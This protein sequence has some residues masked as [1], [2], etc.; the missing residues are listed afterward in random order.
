MTNQL[1]LDRIRAETPGCSHVLHFN[2][3]G[4]SL[5]PQPV[6]DAQL[7]HLKLEAQI[8]GYEAAA[9]A[10]EQIEHTYTAIAQLINAQPAEIAVVENATV[11]WQMAFAS[12]PFKKGD[13]I[14]TAQASYASNYLNFLLTAERTG[15]TIEVIPDDEY[16]QL[17]IEALREMMDE[18]VKLIAITHVPTNSG[19][20]NPAA[21]VGQ[22]ARA[23]ECLYLLDGCQSAGQLPLD[24][25]AIGCDLLSATGRKFLRGPRGSGFLY[26]RQNKLEQL[27]PP[28]IDLHSAKWIGREV[29][30]IRPDARRFENWENNYAAKIG[31][32]VAVDYA[33]A[34]GMEPI[35][36][37]LTSLAAHLRESLSTISGVQVHDHGRVKGGIVTFAVE[38]HSAVAIKEKLQAQQINTSTT[39]VFSTRLD[40][41]ARQLPDLVRASVH[42]FNTEA[43]IGRFCEVLSGLM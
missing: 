16:G 35:W 24:V 37:R 31:L 22:V 11:G 42:Y 20:V 40:M 30:E 41:E 25:E 5:M 38:G 15:A 17:S 33:L 32:G 29:Y 23:W 43:E 13:R 7:D 1:D 14:L 19:L 4:S 9:Q 21:E 36:E 10:A 18:R 12:V 8:G 34:I 2:N 26:A 27:I 6:L 3:A 28:F 39:T